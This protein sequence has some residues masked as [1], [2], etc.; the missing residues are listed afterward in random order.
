MRGL[1]DGR[2][3]IALSR[4]L[5]VNRLTDGRAATFGWCV[6]DQVLEVNGIPVDDEESF[7]YELKHAGD[8]HRKTGKPLEFKIVRAPLPGHGPPELPG[9][10]AE[11][12]PE[13][14]PHHKVRTGCCGEHSEAG[15]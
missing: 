4:G 6:G 11:E 8:V 5:R 3:G 12:E 1:L 2:V 10:D 13:R 15:Q 9:S 14:H 7:M